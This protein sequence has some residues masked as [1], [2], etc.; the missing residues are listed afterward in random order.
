MDLSQKLP[1]GVCFIITSAI[2]DDLDTEGETYK[3]IENFRMN[4]LSYTSTLS[5]SPDEAVKLADIITDVF[6]NGL[7]Y[8]KENHL[9]DLRET[10]YY[11]N[12]EQLGLF[13]DVDDILDET[14]FKDVLDD[15][16]DP[17]EEGE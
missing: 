14:G 7:E 15:I 5:K 12:M 3:K 2:I 17:F 16:D 9:E 13:G 10:D 8:I 1:N 6:Q 11:D 4:A